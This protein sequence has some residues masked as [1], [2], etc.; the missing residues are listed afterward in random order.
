MWLQS[1]L[2]TVD[3]HEWYAPPQIY[4]RDDSTGLWTAK[5][6]FQPDSHLLSAGLN[7]VGG[8]GVQ[9]FSVIGGANC[10]DRLHQS[11]NQEL[12]DSVTSVET[13]C[14]DASDDAQ[15]QDDSAGSKKRRVEEDLSANG[16]VV[17][18]YSLHETREVKLEDP[19]TVQNAILRDFQGATA[20][21]ANASFSERVIEPTLVMF[22]VIFFEI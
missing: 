19:N 9:A 21:T 11:N 22:E 8:L 17:S 5:P 13:N 4:T 18:D 16:N 6:A 1:V 3:R 20:T 10:M 2:V 12:T 14:E 15:P 7:D